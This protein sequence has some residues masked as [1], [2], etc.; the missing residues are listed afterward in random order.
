MAIAKNWSAVSI[1]GIAG[2]EL[3]VKGEA[4]TGLL[5]VQPELEKRVP[6]GSNPAI[7]QLDLL[8]ASNAK[9]GHF[10]PVQYNEKLDRQNKY[11]LVEIFHRNEVIAKIKV[12]HDR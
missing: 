8:H 4:N 6:Q 3:I 11:E 10:Q 1:I 9:P 2:P 12:K 7:L 5:T